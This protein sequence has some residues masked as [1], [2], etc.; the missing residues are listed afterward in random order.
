[1][2]EREREVFEF[3]ISRSSLWE[4]VIQ[5]F[6]LQIGIILLNNGSGIDVVLGLKLM[7]IRYCCCLG[8]KHELDPIMAF[9]FISLTP[10]FNFFIKVKPE[11]ASMGRFYI[12]GSAYIFFF[13]FTK[14]LRKNYK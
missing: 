1:M 13:F 12:S 14:D 7:W 9:P 6:C 5:H 3:A 2:R 4:Q 10:V 11:Q 8:L